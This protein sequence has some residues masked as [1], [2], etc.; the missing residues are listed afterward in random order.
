MGET[1]QS[2]RAVIAYELVVPPLREQLLRSALLSQRSVSS[3]S[4]KTAAALG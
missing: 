4:P 2:M 1:N 3:L